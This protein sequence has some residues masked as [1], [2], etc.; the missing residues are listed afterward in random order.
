MT[1]KPF[2]LEVEENY[3]IDRVKELIQEK[4]GIL[5]GGQTLV[6]DGT[7]LENGHTLADYN[8]L[9]GSTLIL[10][11]EYMPPVTI[12]VTLNL[13]PFI[14]AKQNSDLL[15]NVVSSRT[16]GGIESYAG[17][18]QINVKDQ[19]SLWINTFAANGQYLDTDS[20]GLAMGFEKKIKNFKYGIGYSYLQNDIEGIIVNTDADTHSINRLLGMPMPS[21]H[22]LTRVLMRKAWP[23][24]IFRPL[25]LNL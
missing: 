16:S 14:I 11:G 19:T 7:E 5:S 4:I 8:I 12:D 20:Y 18:E 9:P 13:S 10:I 3:T 6:Y 1:E 22:I 2:T 25:G 21:Y 17:A 23:N 24:I 15:F